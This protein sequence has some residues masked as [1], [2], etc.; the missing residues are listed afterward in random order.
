[1][2]FYER[3]KI[4]VKAQDTTIEAAVKTASLTRGAWYTYQR[5]G[6]LPRVDEA[7]SVAR[8]L[9][10][11]VDYLVYGESAKD[12]VIPARISSIVADLLLLKDENIACVAKMIHALVDDVPAQEPARSP[13][14]PKTPEFQPLKDGK[15]KEKKA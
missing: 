6:L 3:V 4:E 12:S 14:R 15:S 2:D 8:F 13:T 1:V 9:H 7:L 5:R 11:S 10:T